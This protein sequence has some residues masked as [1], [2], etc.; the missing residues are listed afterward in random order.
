MATDVIEVDGN[1]T[2]DRRLE[3][4]EVRNNSVVLKGDQSDYFLFHKLFLIAPFN[5][6]SIVT[7]TGN[8]IVVP[9]NRVAE[10]LAKVEFKVTGT[11]ALDGLYATQSAVYDPA[12]G[13]TTI[14]TMGNA[15]PVGTVNGGYVQTEVAA[16]AVVCGFGKWNCSDWPTRSGFRSMSLI[17]LPEPASG[18]KLNI[19]C[20]HTLA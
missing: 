19:A 1:H 11:N 14:T 16:M 4:L 20:S 5:V 13:L 9:G 8:E 17:C 7:A 3:I 10:F 18:I 6:Y 12:E 15:F 2:F